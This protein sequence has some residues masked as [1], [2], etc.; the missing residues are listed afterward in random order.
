MALICANAFF[1]QLTPIFEGTGPAVV[2]LNCQNMTR[3]WKFNTQLNTGCLLL[4]LKS[5]NSPMWY[6]ENITQPMYQKA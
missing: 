2:V 3:K 1:F 5:P 6:N 4:F